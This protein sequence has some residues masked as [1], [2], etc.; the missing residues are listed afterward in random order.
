MACFG[1]IFSLKSF[2]VVLVE[3]GFHLGY[4]G[5]YWLALAG[6][7]SFRLVLACFGSLRPFSVFIGEF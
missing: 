2:W 5:S 3:F 6:F 4:F 7:G 1:S